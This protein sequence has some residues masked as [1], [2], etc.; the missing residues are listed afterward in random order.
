MSDRRSSPAVSVVI[1]TAGRRQCLPPCVESLRRQSYG[2][3]EI[4][5]VVGPSKDGS[6]GYAST[7]TDAK[8]CHVDKLNVAYARNEGV[9]RSSGDIIAFIDDDAMAHP[10]WVAELVEA[11][12]REGPDLRR[13]R[14]PG[15]QRERPRPAGPGAQQHDQRARRARRG[16]A[17]PR[18]AQRPGRDP[19]QLLHGRQHGV[20]SRG[21]P[22]GRRVRRD[23][24]L[25]V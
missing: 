17:R 2:P 4:V 18:R 25:P 11:F 19:I 9:R 16:P 5:V 6:A 3:I 23:V 21:D 15:H 7:L 24:F 14:R 22:G 1:I 20:P 10:R 12:E 13:G 8:V